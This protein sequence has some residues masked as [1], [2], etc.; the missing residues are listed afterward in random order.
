MFTKD[1]SKVFL[2]GISLFALLVLVGHNPGLLAS[3]GRNNTLCRP[4]GETCRPGG[5]S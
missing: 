1:L 3:A 4:A 5:P 2:F